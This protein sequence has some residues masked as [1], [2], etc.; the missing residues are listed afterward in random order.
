[1]KI[2]VYQPEVSRIGGSIKTILVFA[3]TFKEFGHIV[4]ITTSSNY[5]P[6]IGDINDVIKFYG[7]KNISFDDFNFEIEQDSDFILTHSSRGR[8][9]A[10]FNPGVPVIYWCVRYRPESNYLD[11]WTNSNTTNEKLGG[12]LRVVY[13]PHDYSIFRKYS[14]QNKIYDICSVIRLDGEKKKK[15]YDEL[16][17]IANK[18][19]KRMIVVIGDTNFKAIPALKCD[20]IKNLNKE[21]LA[22]IL[23]Q[24]KIFL[25]TSDKESASL[26][27]YEALN[28][29]C[30]VIG[31]EVGAI[32]EQT[33]NCSYIYNGVNDLI[34]FLSNFLYSYDN[35]A[36][37]KQD[38]SS[39]C[40]LQ[41]WEFDKEHQIERLKGVLKEIECKLE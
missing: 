20:T 3:D 14:K 6:K 38:I 13:P 35:K 36:N 22:Q 8:P 28:S 27:I 40:I 21:E 24:S 17:E 25:L 5:S 4:K 10:N 39:K 31:K 34:D 19:K 2:T 23:G 32:R 12:G 7:L 33:N 18:L 26:S 1:M 15:G 30:F 41:G 16:C 9:E 29:G 11:L 37:Y